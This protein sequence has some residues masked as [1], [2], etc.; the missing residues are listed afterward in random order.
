MDKFKTSKKTTP[1]VGCA[2]PTG[3]EIYHSTVETA[4]PLTKDRMCGRSM[5]SSFKEVIFPSR[6]PG[7]SQSVSDQDM[8]NGWYA[9]RNILQPLRMLRVENASL[10]SRGRSR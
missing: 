10:L 2:G 7:F 1:T 8:P 6:Y 9:T 5:L 4:E 3:I